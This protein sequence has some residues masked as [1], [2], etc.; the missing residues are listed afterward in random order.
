[1]AKI[2]EINEMEQVNLHGSVGKNGVN[3]KGDVLAVQALMKYAL[4]ER[5]KWN[6]LTFPEPTG[7]FD[8][9]TAALIKLVQQH[10]RKESRGGVSV[11]GR[12]DPAKGSRAFGRRGL[13]TIMIL[14]TL[15]METWI[16]NNA[17]NGSYIRDMGIKYPA[18]R[19][20]IGDSGVGTLNLELEG[21]KGI[22]TLGLELE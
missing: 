14:N 16:L 17:K 1:M 22:G 21:G 13:W 12:V 15:A 4:A 11:D 7:T 5:P 10:A 8:K 2:D 9:A 19:W 18:F 3:S 20:A 6:L